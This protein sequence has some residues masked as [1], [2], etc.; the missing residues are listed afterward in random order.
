[1]WVY[2]LKP[3]VH[4]YAGNEGYGLH[5]GVE[6]VCTALVTIAPLRE[7]PLGFDSLNV[8]VATGIILH[9]LQQNRHKRHELHV[10]DEIK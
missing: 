7:L 9:S 2:K 8:A 10:H 4:L 1:M 6:K 3:V 5:S